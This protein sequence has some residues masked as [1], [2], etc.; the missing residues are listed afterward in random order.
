MQAI[1][2]G[3]LTT[4]ALQTYDKMMIECVSKI[5]NFAPLATLIWAN[6]L[7]E[8]EKR[9]KAKLV[10]GSYDDLGNALIHRLP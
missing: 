3:N 10:S 5:E 9:G 1:E 8:L 2:T 4:A 7:E 6:V